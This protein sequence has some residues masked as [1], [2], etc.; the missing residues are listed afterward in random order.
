MRT[1][2]CHRIW[3]LT[4]AMTALALAATH[5]P[6][7]ADT[8]PGA[9]TS[10]YLPLTGNDTDRA[11]AHEAGC[12]EGRAGHDGIRFLALG[13]QEDNGLLRRPGVGA[14]ST[15]E[16]TPTEQA[17]AAA[18]SWAQGFTE[19]RT[20]DAHAE[21][22]LTVNNKSDGD[23]N[24]ADAGRQ[25]AD[26]VDDAAAADNSAVTITGGIDAE[27]S[28]SSPE[29]ARNWVDAFT[30]ATHR[31]LYAG[32]SADGCPQHGSP[33]TPCSN[34][35]TLAD[36]HYVSSGAASSIEAVPQIY[37]TDGTQARQWA[38]ISAWGARNGQGTI[39]FA[40]AMSQNTACSQRGD[41]S[42]T[43]NTP[44]AAWNQLWEE[45]NTHPETQIPALPTATDIRWP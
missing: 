37:R 17:A 12:A 39:R 21:L 7:A 15:S 41:C 8:Y 28:W 27:P 23:T 20:D 32:N 24:G 33:A 38:A 29:W 18:R 36:V 3:L 44:E 22:A 16:R 40:G 6:A 1:T 45:L 31:T 35:W 42:H 19:C 2:R 26:I 9:T 4:T 30:E 34:G 11:A 14:T 43:D 25:W 5:T 13:T 10:H